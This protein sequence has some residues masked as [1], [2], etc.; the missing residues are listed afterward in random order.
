MH[1]FLEVL[2]D[3]VAIGVPLPDPRLMPRCNMK[4]QLIATISRTVDS[5]SKEGSDQM[6]FRSKVLIWSPFEWLLGA[7]KQVFDGRAVS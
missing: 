6:Y 7:A 4:D 5:A 3:F 1:R 2:P